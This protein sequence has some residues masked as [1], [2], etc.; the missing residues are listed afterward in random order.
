MSAVNIQRILLTRRS[1]ATSYVSTH[2]EFEDLEHHRHHLQETYQR[3]ISLDGPVH[4]LLDDE[5]YA[6]GSGYCKQRADR[7]KRARR[8]DNC[9]NQ[10]KVRDVTPLITSSTGFA[11]T[12]HSCSGSK[13]A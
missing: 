4:D 1:N 10:D 12:T 6:I 13:S 3:L 8:T 5:K 9:D 11:R 2:E 7:S